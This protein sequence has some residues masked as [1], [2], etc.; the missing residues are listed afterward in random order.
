MNHAEIASTLGRVEFKQLVSTHLDNA[1]RSFN[2]AVLSE[3]GNPVFGS[4]FNCWS[5]LGSCFHSLNQFR[6]FLIGEGASNHA[7]ALNGFDAFVLGKGF[8]LT[9]ARLNPLLELILADVGNRSEAGPPRLIIGEVRLACGLLVG[10]AVHNLMLVKR[11]VIV[12][13][14][15]DK[16]IALFGRVGKEY[17]NVVAVHALG[18][19]DISVVVLH[20]GF[21]RLAVRS[22]TTA[23]TAFGVL[24]ADVVAVNTAVF[25][26][27]VACGFLR[28]GR[29]CLL[30]LHTAVNVVSN[31]L[32]VAEI[33]AVKG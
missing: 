22:S 29:F 24:D 8:G 5:N 26:L 1:D 9:S 19:T 16:H 10:E 33:A 28:L 18:A 12:H 15:D 7:V 32:E 25:H 27:I 23:H 17:V 14:V 21:P 30:C 4:E 20:D 31:L 11:A 13:L 6:C 2:S 3:V